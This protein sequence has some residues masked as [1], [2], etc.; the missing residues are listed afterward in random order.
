LELLCHR[1][2]QRRS[3]VARTLLKREIKKEQI[4]PN[5]QRLQCAL[6]VVNFL[7]I[8]ATRQHVAHLVPEGLSTNIF[9]KLRKMTLTKLILINVKQYM[10]VVR[11]IRFILFHIGI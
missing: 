8:K 9:G 5:A 1:S 10:A 2:W 6:D 7:R 11:H 4:K 3:D